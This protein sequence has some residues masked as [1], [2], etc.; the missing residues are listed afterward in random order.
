MVIISKRKRLDSPPNGIRCHRGNCSGLGSALYGAD[1]YLD[2]VTGDTL[3]ESLGEISI[4]AFSFPP[5]LG[6]D[7]TT[8]GVRRPKDYHRTEL[9][10][11]CAPPQDW[12]S[13]AEWHDKAVGEFES[14]LPS[15]SPETALDPCEKIR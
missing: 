12:E 6:I 13:L 7:G 15:P 8:F 9:F 14:S 11:W 2:E 10:W 4:P 5:V 1:A 3:F